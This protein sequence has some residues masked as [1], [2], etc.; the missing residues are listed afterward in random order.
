MVSLSQII[1]NH[2]YYFKYPASSIGT[3]ERDV[4]SNKK[5]NLYTDFQWIF[6]TVDVKWRLEWI[7]FVY[8]IY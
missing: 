3:D 6:N 1:T 5:R 8:V 4:G 2:Y 7:V